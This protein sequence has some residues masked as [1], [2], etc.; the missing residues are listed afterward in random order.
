MVF[1]N[2][3]IIRQ[4]IA[5][6][7]LALREKSEAG[8]RQKCGSYVPA[9]LASLSMTSPT[10]LLGVEAPAVSPMVSGE[11]PGSQ[12]WEI[13]SARTVVDGAPTGRWRTSPADTRHSGSAM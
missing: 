2:L 12:W 10:M 6:S 9:N 1:C 5:G 13:S 3:L 7:Q 8:S 11:V 4:K